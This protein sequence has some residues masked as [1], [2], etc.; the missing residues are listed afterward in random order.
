MADFTLIKA[1][2][3]QGEI[4][5]S[6]TGSTGDGAGLHFDGSAG[7]IDIASPPDLGTKFSFEFVIKAD[8]T[9]S[10]SKVVD[11]GDGGRFV[12]EHNTTGLQVKPSNAGGWVT[13]QSPSPLADLEVHH[14][15]LTVDGTTATL[16]D[17][18]NQVATATISATDIDSCADA[19]IGSYYDSATDLFAG[20]IYRARFYNHTLSADEVRTA[21]E[22]A[23][24]PFA[25]QYRSQTEKR[26]R[27]YYYRQ[28][29]R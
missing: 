28:R 25:D 17:N 13:I 18:G 2:P 8:S 6:L 11:F 29:K 14:L 4:T 10:S 21:F 5:S 26:C 24:V 3:T 22:R 1:N 7:N 27:I 12:I 9:G 16:F 19:K 15:V 23:D 20:T